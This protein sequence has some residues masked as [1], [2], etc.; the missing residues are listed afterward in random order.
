MLDGWPLVDQLAGAVGPG[1]ADGVAE[2]RWDDCLPASIAAVVEY[3]RG[4]VVAPDH[5]KDWA[6]GDGFVGYTEPSRV[7]PFLSL[8]GIGYEVRRADAE[9]AKEATKAAL[10]QGWPVVARS[11]EPEGF[12]HYCPVVGYED[13][14]VTRHN[15]LGGRRETLSWRDW[16]HRYAGWLVIVR[17]T[18]S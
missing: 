9:D 12:Y 8:W 15:P 3:L 11:F 6:Y 18:K 10:R 2:N 13:E 7:A 16:L 4:V 5:I 1:D 14:T 17:E